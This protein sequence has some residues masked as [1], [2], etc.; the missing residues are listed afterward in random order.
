MSRQ[1]TCKIAKQPKYRLSDGAARLGP[2]SR[3]RA[4]RQTAAPL[5]TKEPSALS[6]ALQ[7]L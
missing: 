3:R 7:E 4:G 1:S 5:H 6:E 2:S